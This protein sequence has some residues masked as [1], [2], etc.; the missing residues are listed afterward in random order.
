MKE[1]IFLTKSSEETQ[2]LAQKLARKLKRDE[3]IALFGNL[4]SGKTTFVQGL[5]RGLGIKQR[6]ISPTFIIIRK[7]QISNISPRF[8]EAGEFPISNFYHIDLYRI[9]KTE[10]LGL[11]EI[12]NSRDGIIA[13]EWAEK[14]EKLLPKKRIEIYF[15]NISENERKITLKKY[16]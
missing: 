14:I 7:Y 9:Q 15:E 5:A 1:E 2:N 3:V 13:I 6:I 4:G 16:G 12:I 10:G 8:G 11:E